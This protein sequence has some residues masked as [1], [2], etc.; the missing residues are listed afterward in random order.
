[1]ETRMRLAAISVLLVVCSVSQAE[2]RRHAPV[3]D[4]WN[5]NGWERSDGSS[6]QRYDRYQPYD[7]R[8]TR[9][10]RHKMH[11]QRAHRSRTVQQ[12]RKQTATR[13]GLVTVPTAAG[14]SITVSPAFATKIVAFIADLVE[15]GYKP[16][17]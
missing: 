9:V 8:R 1:M 2:A 16:K 3:T 11:R 13:A 5:W 4:G 6:R 15:S 10:V 17:R 14:I 12:H 7:T